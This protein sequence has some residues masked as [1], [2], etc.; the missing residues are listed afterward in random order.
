[1]LFC[2][3]A[4]RKCCRYRELLGITYGVAARF[5][6]SS[7]V[8][9]HAPAEAIINATTFGAAC[10]DQ[11]DAFT[12]VQNYI[13]YFGEIRPKLQP[14]EALL[15][16][17]N[18]FRAAIMGS[19]TA[20]TSA[21]RKPNV[22]AVYDGVVN[23]VGCSTASDTFACLSAVDEDTLFNAVNTYDPDSLFQIRP[24]APII[25]GELIPD[26]PFTLISEGNFATTPFITGHVVDEG[27]RFVV[28]Q[29]INTTDDFLNAVAIVD[30]PTL[31]PSTFTENQ[32]SYLYTV[33]KWMPELLTNILAEHTYDP[34]D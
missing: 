11:R 10:P 29:A 13:S 2:P 30:S 24:W 27:T 25:D 12:W 5:K 4:K 15:A 8:S 18:L 31:T 1:M 16:H 19:G 17:S 23:L 34:V 20:S 9:Y 6:R 26:D 22:Q 3:G 21:V 32:D 33:K 7:P 28:P 14:S